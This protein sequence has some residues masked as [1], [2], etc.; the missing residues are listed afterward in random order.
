M[1]KRSH[2][3]LLLQEGFVAGQALLGRKEGDKQDKYMRASEQLL[4]EGQDNVTHCLCQ[5][6]PMHLGI[7]VAVP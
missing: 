3:S 7:T 6:W 2:F 1:S 4:G 5:V